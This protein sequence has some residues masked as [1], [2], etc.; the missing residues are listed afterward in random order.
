MGYNAKP[1]ISIQPKPPQK[2]P[3]PLFIRCRIWFDSGFK[4]TAD[5]LQCQAEHQHP[6][7]IAVQN[8]RCLFSSAVAFGSTADLRRQRIGYNAKPSIS[9][10]PKWPYK[11]SAASFHPLSYFLRQ[12][13]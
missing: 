4:E 3:L 5:R 13:I 12:R 10:Q 11:T 2:H 6:A 8:I 1:S 7:E 9:I